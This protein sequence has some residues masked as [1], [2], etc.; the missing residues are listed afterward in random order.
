MK[1]T[2]NNW[3]KNIAEEYLCSLLFD[4]NPDV[5]MKEEYEKIE[6]VC[7]KIV[8]DEDLER[9]IKELIGESAEWYYYHLD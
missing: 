1:K 8:E 6:K 4:N 7:R 5:D 9:Q 3:M 2:K